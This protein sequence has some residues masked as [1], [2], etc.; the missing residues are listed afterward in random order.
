[1]GKILNSLLK[2]QWNSPSF[3]CWIKNCFVRHGINRGYNNRGNYNNRRGQNG[4]GYNNENC[5]N[6]S[7]GGYNNY[8][9]N[10]GGG[11]GGYN[12][13]AGQQQQQQ[14]QQ[15]YSGFNS[16]PARDGNMSGGQNLQWQAMNNFAKAANNLS[17]YVFDIY[18][19]I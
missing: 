11:R 13:Q 17:R 10:S 15:G 1:M 14:G 3:I 19:S 12:N 8:N 2:M 9:S 6:N 5:D 7:R 4:G 16:R 18:L